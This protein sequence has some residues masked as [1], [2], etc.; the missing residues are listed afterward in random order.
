MLKWS[1]HHRI[2]TEPICRGFVWIVFPD[3]EVRGTLVRFADCN[4]KVRKKFIA[5]RI[6]E[7]GYWESQELLQYR[8]LGFDGYY[9]R[10]ILLGAPKDGRGKA[11]LRCFENTWDWELCMPVYKLI[12]V[13]GI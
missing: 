9:Q 7:K 4:E 11:C 10:D 6:K 13:K 5:S 1:A 8:R 2:L 12:A 3:G